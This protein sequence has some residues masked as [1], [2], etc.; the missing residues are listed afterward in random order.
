[1]EGEIL[2]SKDLV[3]Q[4]FL[5]VLQ[6]IEKICHNNYFVILFFLEKMAQSP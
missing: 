6:K 5:K 4:V 1:M 2:L 3:P